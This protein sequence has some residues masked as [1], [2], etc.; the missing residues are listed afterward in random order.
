MKEF[1]RPFLIVL[2]LVTVCCGNNATAQKYGWAKHFYPPGP[3]DPSIL[4]LNEGKA[5]AK[6]LSGNL[7]TTGTFADTVDFDPGA[8]T[9]FLS[10]RTPDK[11]NQFIAKLSPEGNLI[12]ADNVGNN[13]GSGGQIYPNAIAVGLDGSVYTTG[14]FT[15]ITVSS[16]T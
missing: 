3:V 1:L 5:M 4:I 13:S 14:Y 9:F 7:Y 11:Q 10:S 12:W 16:V 6:D 15:G 8:G 2:T